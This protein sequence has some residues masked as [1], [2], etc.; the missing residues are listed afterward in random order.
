[1][2]SL[3]G[4]IISFYLRSSSSYLRLLPRVPGPFY[5]HFIFDVEVF[6]IAV[7]ERNKRKVKLYISGFVLTRA[8]NDVFY[9]QPPLPLPLPTGTE[10]DSESL[11]YFLL[12][13]FVARVVSCPYKDRTYA[14]IKMLT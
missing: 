7:I 6:N 10:N 14:T 5:L 3:S 2:L 4:S 11:T 1:V 8:A 13:L 12:P 9:A